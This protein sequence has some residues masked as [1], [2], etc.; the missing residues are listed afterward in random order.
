MFDIG[1]TELL[2]IAVVAI[3]VVGPKDLPRMLRTLG[4]YAGKL[5][6]TANEF[7]RQFDDAIRESEFEDI[8]NSMRDVGD[9]NPMRDIKDT[10]EDTVSPL[11]TASE[12]IK[13]E[14]EKPAV[15]GAKEPA[16]LETAKPEA[17]PSGA[18]PAEKAAKEPAASADQA[19]TKDDASEPRASAKT[20][21]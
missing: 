5:R 10:V 15:S 7:R 14:A 16:K 6:R 3:L 13:R 21:S 11:K 20:G 8:R 9:I 19:A 2:V 17:E 4:N 18:K 12:D 1:W